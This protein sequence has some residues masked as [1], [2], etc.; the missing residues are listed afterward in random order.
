MLHD[1]EATRAYETA[2]RVMGWSA[3]EFHVLTKGQLFEELLG[4][5]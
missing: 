5:S 4:F 3:R 2:L 1:E